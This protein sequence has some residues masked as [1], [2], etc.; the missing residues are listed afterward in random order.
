MR[1]SQVVLLAVTEITQRWGREIITT[2]LHQAS[3]WHLVQSLLMP[4]TWVH[5]PLDTDYC[6]LLVHLYPVP[7]STTDALQFSSTTDLWLLPCDWRSSSLAP[8]FLGSTFFFKSLLAN[9]RNWGCCLIG[10]VQ[11]E[12][13]Q[14]LNSSRGNAWPSDKCPATW[15]FKWVDEVQTPC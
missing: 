7:V 2:T 5:P 14:G 1:F 11:L 13:R 9:D 10:I 4:P 3:K 8:Q 15:S 6:R 12:R